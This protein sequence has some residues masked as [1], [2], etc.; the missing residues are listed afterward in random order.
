MPPVVKLAKQLYLERM[1]EL[2]AQIKADEES[3]RKLVTE[4]DE[5][6]SGKWDTKL[7][8]LFPEVSESTPIEVINDSQVPDDN[9]LSAR[10]AGTDVTTHHASAVPDITVPAFEEKIDV[11]TEVEEKPLDIKTPEA[12]TL[13]SEAAQMFVDSNVNATPLESNTI[14]ADATSLLA[15]TSSMDEKEITLPT[16]EV[17]ETNVPSTTPTGPTPENVTESVVDTVIEEQTPFIPQEPSEMVEENEV[18]TENDAHAEQAEI[19]APAAEV[20]PAVTPKE[21]TEV[22]HD[23]STKRKPDDSDMLSVD[24][25]PKRARTQSRSPS[26]V[27]EPATDALS[28]VIETPQIETPASEIPETEVVHARAETPEGR[29]ETPVVAAVEEMQGKDTQCRKYAYKAPKIVSYAFIVF[30]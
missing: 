24:N 4:I 17:N 25:S 5:I 22:K 30:L 27:T 21:E 6:R 9:S 11:K 15:A 7:K 2:K 13:V 18:M 29:P 12:S 3:F 28:P 16:P 1:E 20:T 10:A 19:L 14:L 23:I 8:E 26:V